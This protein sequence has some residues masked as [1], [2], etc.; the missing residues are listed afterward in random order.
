MFEPDAKKA[1][2]AESLRPFHAILEA[3]SFADDK[4]REKVSWTK[5]GWYDDLWLLKVVR[6]IR[7]NAFLFNVA[8][9]I[10]HLIGF[11]LTA[12]ANKTCA[13][14][15]ALQNE[16]AINGASASLLEIGVLYSKMITL[17]GTDPI[18]AAIIDLELSYI[19]ALIW[20]K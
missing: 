19:S 14:A 1:P 11:L 12:D 4:K 18:M 10:I 15:V 2:F 13:N 7:F 16:W 8:Q 3:V 5:K 6:Q 17:L 9:M 20:E